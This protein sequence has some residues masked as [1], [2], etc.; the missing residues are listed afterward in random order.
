[1]A[2]QLN[3]RPELLRKPNLEKAPKKSDIHRAHQ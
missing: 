3:S 2:S 1:M